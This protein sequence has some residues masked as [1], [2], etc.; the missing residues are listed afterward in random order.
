MLNWLKSLTRRN[1]EMTSLTDGARRQAPNACGKYVP[2]HKYLDNRYATT[3]V[4]TL[5]DIEDVLGFALPASARTD[6][7]WWTS[8]DARTAEGDYS[9]AW[10]LARRTARPNL[11]A[12][13]VVFERIS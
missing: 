11:P 5:V 12:K 1:T 7:E 2:L 4:L 9:Q 10:T 8:A 3:V 6:R 13:N